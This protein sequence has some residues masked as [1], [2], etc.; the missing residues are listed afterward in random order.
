MSSLAIHDSSSDLCAV[1]VETS[2]T[3]ADSEDFIE[4]CVNTMDQ[5]L[6]FADSVDTALTIFLR[7]GFVVIDGGYDSDLLAEAQR[8]VLFSIDAQQLVC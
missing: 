3:R 4:V 1:S 6:Y 7:H 8:E 2:S 5:S